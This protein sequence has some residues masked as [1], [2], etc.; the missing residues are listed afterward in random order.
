M[1]RQ[2]SLFRGSYTDPQIGKGLATALSSIL[3]GCQSRVVVLCIGTDANI[4]DSLG[5]LVGTLL[6]EA[7]SLIPVY[8]TLDQPIHARNLRNRIEMIQKDHPGFLELAI[9]ASAGKKEE[10]GT[11]EIKNCGVY[12]GKA[13]RKRLPLVGHISIL[14]KVEAVQGL[15]STGHLSE[16]RLGMVYRMARIIAQ[17]ILQWERSAI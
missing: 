9:D 7:G 8:G 13:L 14:G 4:A 2:T 10:I 6:V 1:A 11:I 12:P 17:A 16:G 3:G 15:R 5:P